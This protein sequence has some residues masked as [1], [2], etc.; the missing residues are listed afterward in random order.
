MRV[1]MYRNGSFENKSEYLGDVVAAHVMGVRVAVHTAAREH[2]AIATARLAA[3]HDTG[4]SYISVTTGA[5]DAF[6][7]LNDRGGAAA[8][9][10]NETGVLMGAFGKKRRKGNRYYG[11]GDEEHEYHIYEDEED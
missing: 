2:A 5:T 3:H 7:N 9:I 1:R 8:A 6:V 11:A 4:A 10:E